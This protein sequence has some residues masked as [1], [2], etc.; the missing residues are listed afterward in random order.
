MTQVDQYW[1]TATVAM[2]EVEWGTKMHLSC[3]YDDDWGG[4][5]SPPSYALVVRTSD[6]AS[7]RVATW[8]AVPGRTVELD[9]ATDADQGQITRVDVVTADTGRR[10]LMLSPGRS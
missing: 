7:Q 6:G 3:T 4:D 1:L 8:R 2:Q 5:G 9:A 10:V